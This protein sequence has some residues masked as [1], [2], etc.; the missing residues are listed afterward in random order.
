MQKIHVG[1]VLPNTSFRPF[2]QMDKVQLKAWGDEGTQVPCT[3]AGRNPL[4][5][6]RTLQ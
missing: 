5:G 4:G 2:A 3:P 1:I 6:L